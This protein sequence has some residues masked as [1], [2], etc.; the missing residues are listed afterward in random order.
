[1]TANPSIPVYTISIPEYTVDPKPDYAAV[2]RKLDR[3]IESHFQG[4]IVIRGIGLID[5]PGKSLDDLIALVLETGTD[6]YD[7]KREGVHYPEEYL[8][9]I[10]ACPCEVTQKLTSAHYHE[11]R[12]EFGS[13]MA[14]CVGDF[15][16]GALADRGYSIRLDLLLI[17][18]RQQLLGLPDDGVE[19]CCLYTFRQP[20]RKREALLGIVKIL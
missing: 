17:Y 7:A 5:H 12:L 2:G 4:K 19:D 9:A 8:T 13:V 15:Y 11:G 6:R 10:F 20:D 18:D 16:E 14:E 3:A 1:V